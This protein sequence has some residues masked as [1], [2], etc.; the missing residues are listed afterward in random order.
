MPH[1]P[2]NAKGRSFATS[3]SA[4]T[5]FEGCPKRYAR[6]KFWCDTDWSDSEASIWGQRVHTAGEQ[7]LLGQTMTEP[8]LE[9]V[10]QPYARVM[11]DSPKDSMFV[12]LEICLSEKLKPV[13]WFSKEAWFR[14]KLDVTIIKNRHALIADWK[15]GKLKDDPDQLKVFIALLSLVKPELETFSA[16]YIWLKDRKVTT[17]GL[18]IVPKSAVANILEGLFGRI[19]RQLQAWKTENFPARP[20]GLCPWCPAYDKCEYARRS[21]R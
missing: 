14:A 11:R 12:E 3:F 5:D 13:A 18:G 2:K 10:I 9:E 19:E 20:S 16:R 15:T 8:A 17:G 21:G 6:T 1:R 4:L 7:Y